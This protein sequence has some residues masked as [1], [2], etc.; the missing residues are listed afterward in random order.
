[1]KSLISIAVVTSLALLL[2]ACSNTPS[3]TNSDTKKTTEPAPSMASS[4]KRDDTGKPEN[5]K[6]AEKKGGQVVESGPYH[7]EFSPSKESGSTHLD[8]YLQ[9]SDT[10]QPVANAK[11]TAQV[12]L[13]D[14]TSKSL[15]LVYDADGKHY[16]AKLPDTAAGDYKVTIISDITGEKVNGRFTFS[17]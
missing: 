16:T 5:S 13:P 14:A 1:M 3:A 15:E 7:L 2:G 6:E 12:T 4:T 10:H 11:V 17:Q 9:K 8:F